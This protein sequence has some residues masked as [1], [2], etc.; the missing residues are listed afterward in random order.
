MKNF[1]QKDDVLT[2]VA[3]YAVASGGGML[4]GHIFGVAQMDAAQ[5]ALVA[6]VTEDCFNLAKHAGDTFSAGDLVYWD[7]ANKVATSTAANNHLIGG[8]IVAAAGADATVRLR[9]NGVTV[10]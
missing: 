4:V 3:P 8:A 2:L 9:L 6:V 10:P 5:G 1:V 7:D